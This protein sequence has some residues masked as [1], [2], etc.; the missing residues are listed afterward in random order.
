MMEAIYHKIDIEKEREHQQEI[1]AKLVIYETNI[2][3]CLRRIK[4]M[5]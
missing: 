5:K 2:W 1:R 4:D 3:A